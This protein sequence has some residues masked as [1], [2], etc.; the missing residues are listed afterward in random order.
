MNKIFNKNWAYILFILII[1]EFFIHNKFIV[2][3]D[4]G[5]TW[6]NPR[7]NLSNL[8]FTWSNL[9]GYGDYLAN[10]ITGIPIIGYYAILSL[11]S[12][13][14][15]VIQKLSWIIFCIGFGIPALIIINKYLK[16][17]YNSLFAV[18]FLLFNH[19]A[20][21]Y[22]WGRQ[23][24][25][26]FL[27]FPYF[28]GIY[29]YIRYLKTSKLAYLIKISLLW[30][31]FG[32]GF[33]QPAFF[34]SFPIILFI[35][36]LFVIPV[37]ENKLKFLTD[38]LVF[39]IFFVGINYGYLS[40]LVTG[41]KEILDFAINTY[42]PN[43]YIP[44]FQDLRSMNV[45][46]SLTNFSSGYDN[47]LWN[48]NFF[49]VM[50]TL[51]IIL[52]FY[53]LSG[54]IKKSI[55]KIDTRIYLSIG[56]IFII[57]LFF[58]K[59]I[60]YPFSSVSIAL[61]N[62]K[63]LYMLRD[64]KDKFSTGYSL[65][66]SLIYILALRSGGIKTKY[67]LYF[68][69]IILC[70][71][72]ILG[73]WIVN[74]NQDSNT[75]VYLQNLPILRNKSSRILNLPLTNYSYFYTSDPPYASDS[76][77]RNIF[78]KDVIFCTWQGQDKLTLDIR[79][80]F[81]KNIFNQEVFFNYLKTYNIQYIL[82]HNNSS[83]NDDTN[84]QYY[85]KTLSSLPYLNLIT[86]TNYNSL[87]EFKEFY[88]RV[89]AN[90][91]IFTKINPIKYTVNLNKVSGD[92]KISLLEGY[93]AKW[94]AYLLKYNEKEQCL[95]AQKFANT[96][97]L[98]CQNS[99]YK[100]IQSDDIGLVPRKEI[101]VPNIKDLTYANSWIINSDL[102]KKQFPAEYYRINKDGSI[103][104]NIVLYF[105]PQNNYYLGMLVSGLFIILSLTLIYVLKKRTVK[106]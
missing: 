78:G 98:E 69:T 23:N 14:P 100:F 75:F 91:S 24:F 43:N 102:I 103:D 36:F 70:S 105:E 9:H 50:I 37:C 82:L 63:L 16:N 86:T 31:I 99:G 87:Y 18:L 45:L 25:T 68:Y 46:Y 57:Y 39:A 52:C 28:F 83:V 64:F 21:I 41:G 26:H 97:T 62:H 77:F 76:P 17:I 22:F 19:V 38:H 85:S 4:A 58:T 80:M 89:I 81:V 71:I 61:F 30:F 48:N 59:G 44:I 1:F 94:K 12:T 33:T 29:F 88:P 55:N 54:V 66:F 60:S 104:L 6:F 92:E 90:H 27:I 79:N 106:S 35:M 5:N 47:Y 84:I 51:T 15:E 20:Q 73:L 67:F 8:F 65:I 93:H 96:D 10:N 40:A 74:P 34:I 56:A 42:S 95:D 3:S 49:L 13:E 32:F 11:I 72:F 2:F 53:T 101:H 7:Y